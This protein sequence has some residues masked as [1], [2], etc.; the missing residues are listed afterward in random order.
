MAQVATKSILTYAEVSSLFPHSDRLGAAQVAFVRAERGRIYLLRAPGPAQYWGRGPQPPFFWLG[1][2]R[3]KT[4]YKTKTGPI[5]SPFY[6]LV[7]SL[8]VAR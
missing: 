4:T 7:L 1:K 3:T 6:D 8:L 5:K 2:K